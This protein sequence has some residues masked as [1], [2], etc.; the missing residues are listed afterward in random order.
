MITS[1]VIM[2]KYRVVSEKYT[3][4]IKRRNFPYIQAKTKISNA[5]KSRNCMIYHQLNV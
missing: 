4:D 1:L 2:N 5:M 3:F